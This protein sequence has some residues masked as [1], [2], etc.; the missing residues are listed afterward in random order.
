MCYGGST[1]GSARTESLKHGRPRRAGG[2]AFEAGAVVE[3]AAVAVDDDRVRIAPRGA[4][5]LRG[6]P[7]SR[8]ISSATSRGPLRLRMCFSMV[9][10]LDVRTMTTVRIPRTT[11]ESTLRSSSWCLRRNSAMWLRLIGAP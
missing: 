2:G 3:L 5:T 7:E 10:V 6:R 9:S 8:T 1:N 11:I 4:G